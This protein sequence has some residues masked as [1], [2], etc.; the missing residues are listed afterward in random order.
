MQG[1]IAERN[2]GAVFRQAPPGLRCA[3]SGLHYPGHI[4]GQVRDLLKS[5]YTPVQRTLPKN[6]DLS[7]GILKD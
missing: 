4:P 5:A 3:S 2:P 6:K 1:A 7:Q